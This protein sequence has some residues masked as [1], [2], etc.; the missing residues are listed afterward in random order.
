MIPTTLS[1]EK[2]RHVYDQLCEVIPGGVNSPVRSCKAVLDFPIVAERGWGDLVFDVDGNGYIDYCMSWGALIHGHAHPEVV[3]AAVS[4]VQD[5]S[6]FGMTTEGEEKLARKIR[7]SLPSMEKI[8][9]VSS[10][11]EATMSAI[12]L[13]RGFSGKDLLVKFSGNFHGHA[14]YLLIKA[15]SGV[16]GINAEATSAGIPKGI[17]EGTAVLPYNDEAAFTAFMQLHG[18]KVGAIIVEPIAGNMGTVPAKKPFLQALRDCGAPL[19]FD[20]VING[21]RVGKNGAQGLYGITPDLTCLSKIIGG[22]FPAG[23]FGGRAEIMDKLAPLG[24]VYQGGTLSGNPVAMAAGL[25][26][27]ELIDRPHFYEELLRKTD[28]L[29]VPLRQK[30]QKKNLNACLQQV[31]SMFTLFFGARSVSAADE[32]SQLDAALFKEFFNY[33]FERGIYIPPLQVEAWFI[34]MAHTEEHLTYTRDV[35]L[36]FIERMC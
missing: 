11:T 2:S 23:A 35:C 18:D 28:L 24:Q 25:K 8:R 22:G 32:L 20:E 13:A 7:E 36:E 16:R 26:T 10:G 33:L 31:G 17:L 12:R 21:F 14:D 30:I 3:A 9:F 15:G 4:R 1:R 6:T 34:S 27:L 29:T 19:I 5:G